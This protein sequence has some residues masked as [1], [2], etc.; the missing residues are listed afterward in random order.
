MKELGHDIYHYL[1][2]PSLILVSPPRTWVKS[3]S[4]SFYGFPSDHRV[5]VAYPGLYHPTSQAVR[6][7]TVLQSQYPEPARRA[8]SGDRWGLEALRN[9]LQDIVPADLLA[10]TAHFKRAEISTYAYENWISIHVKLEKMQEYRASRVAG[11]KA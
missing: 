3:A 11:S 1:A 5:P 8:L 7:R 4:S 9:T 10:A 6:L 2:V